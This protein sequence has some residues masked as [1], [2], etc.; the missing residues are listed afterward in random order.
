MLQ[1]H[2]FEHPFQSQKDLAE[3]YGTSP[4]TISK[5][6]TKMI[7]VLGDEIDDML[8]DLMDFMEEDVGPESF[9]DPSITM[10][11]TM[12]DLQRVIE[13]QDFDSDEELEAFLEQLNENQEI[14]APA[15]SPR[16]RAQDKLF[17]AYQA[18]G[19]ERNKLIKEALDRTV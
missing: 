9:E 7:E 11:K 3:E 1:H 15:T 8:E 12:R 18:R 5:H 10:E 14:M 17:E 19:S 6:S 4:T 2:V 16:D 13:E